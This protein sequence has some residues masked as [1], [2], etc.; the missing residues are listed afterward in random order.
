M[1]SIVSSKGQVTIPR[2]VREELGLTEGAPVEF[3]PQR[4]GVLLRKNT[5]GGHPV[6]QVF[7]TLH[8]SQPVNQL[9]REM[10]EPSK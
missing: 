1:K 4:E 2:K 8:L 3:I 7:G 10:R 5:K 6:D 9:I